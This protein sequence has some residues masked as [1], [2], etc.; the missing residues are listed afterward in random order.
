M[1][2]IALDIA[3]L[4]P[5]Q[6]EPLKWC[7]YGATIKNYCF[8]SI[9]I[10][11]FGISDSIRVTSNFG[12]DSIWEEKCRIWICDCLDDENDEKLDVEGRWKGRYLFKIKD[13]PIQFLT[14]FFFCK[15]LFRL[16]TSNLIGS[17]QSTDFYAHRSEMSLRCSCWKVGV[18]TRVRQRTIK[19]Q[20]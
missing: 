13:I 4:S 16:F 18:V 11:G 6:N 10:A 17:F 15:F 8:W 19:S 14:R 9:S 3:R 1:S 7:G 5:C 2:N 12:K 20:F